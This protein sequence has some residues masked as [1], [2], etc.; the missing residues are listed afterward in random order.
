MNRSAPKQTNKSGYLKYQPARNSDFATTKLVSRS[1]TNAPARLALSTS[2]HLTM[3]C[4][5]DAIASARMRNP[6]A[7]EA[8]VAKCTRSGAPLYER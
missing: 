3:S 8:A 4:A 1:N 6:I 2:F 7:N 5:S